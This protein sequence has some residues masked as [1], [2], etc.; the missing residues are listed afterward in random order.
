MFVLKIKMNFFN[1]GYSMRLS[2]YFIDM[3]QDLVYY[4]LN[5]KI[6][7]NIIQTVFKIMIIIIYNT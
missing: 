5:L 2:L 7:I 1:V 6:T 4:I 3:L